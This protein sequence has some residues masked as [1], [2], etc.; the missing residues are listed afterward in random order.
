MLM[1]LDLSTKE[2]VA[3]LGQFEG[4]DE[5]T[6]RRLLERVH[7]VTADD[8]Q[9][10]LTDLILNRV[11]GSGE[12]IAL[13]AER[14][15]GS[16]H[17]V[18]HRLF[19]ETKTK[20]KRAHGAGPPPVRSQHAGR[21]ETGSEGIV[22]NIITQIARQYRQ[23]FLNHPGPDLIRHRRVRCFMLVTD[24]IGSGDQSSL[25]LDAAWRLASTKSWWSGGF[26]RFEVVCYSATA[27]GLQ[28][29]LNHPCHP[30]VTQVT[31]CPTLS[32]FQPYGDGDMV[33]LCES[34]GPKDSETK[35]PRLGYGGLGALVAFA[36]GM[37]NNAPRLLYQKGR[38]WI[39]LFPHRVTSAARRANHQDNKARLARRLELLREK[40]IALLVRQSGLDPSTDLSVLVLAALKKR[41]R[42]AEAVSAK[43]D[44][45]IAETRNAID[46]ARAAGWIDAANRLTP[47]AY[48]ELEFLR[49][50]SGSK[51]VRY[52]PNNAPYFPDS[53]RV[54]VEGFS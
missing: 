1:T 12:P 47:R 49:R 11:G 10:D 9:D 29:L 50:P 6:A 51:A 25:Y 53:L 48:Q 43:T 37:P 23:T 41:P 26:L 16:R 20:V 19:K 45:G 21:H 36:H 38:N 24:F 33:S 8:F 28:A 32:S 30:M 7:Y 2:A 39:P 44:I 18:A 17:G 5:A 54:P 14:K 35:I 31:A 46:R 3:W 13:Y 40:K 34:Y 22:A 42:T 52:T 4:H 27:V 15:V